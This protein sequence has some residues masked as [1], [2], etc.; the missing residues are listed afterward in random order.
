M[1]MKLIAPIFGSLLLL[2][3]PILAQAPATANHPAVE[4]IQSTTPDASVMK[5]RK[6]SYSFKIDN[7]DW[8]DTGVEVAPGDH[9]TFT[10]SGNVALADGRSSHPMA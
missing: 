2:S 5:A 6:G 9:L 1:S 4:V 10:A 3:S 7:G 8:N